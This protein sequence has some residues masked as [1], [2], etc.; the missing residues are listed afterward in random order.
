M[1]NCASAPSTASTHLARAWAAGWTWSVRPDGCAWS[2]SISTAAPAPTAAAS[3]L[4]TRRAG[5]APRQTHPRNPH[6]PPP[7]RRFD[8]V[9]ESRELLV[10]VLL[11]IET[12]VDR[13]PR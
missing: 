6:P 4:A 10:E 1:R 9:D 5:S 12:A 11:G 13:E 8:L 2:T 7:R 3:I